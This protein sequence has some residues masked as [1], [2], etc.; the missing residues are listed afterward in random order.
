MHELEEPPPA[1]FLGGV[2]QD[3]APGLVDLEEAPIQA[4]DAEKVEI[5][6]EESLEIL[7]LPAA[8]RDVDEQ[9]GEERR[10]RGMDVHAVPASR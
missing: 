2:A 10:L 3:P 8:F 7:R 5:D 1:Q 9:D 6:R 4:C